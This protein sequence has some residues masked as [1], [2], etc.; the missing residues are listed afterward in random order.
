MRVIELDGDLRRQ[1]IQARIETAMAAQNVLQRAGYEKDLLHET[2]LL[3]ALGAVV[4]V[5]HL[6]DGLARITL[7]HRFDV[8]TAIESPKIEL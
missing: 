4:G 6:R 8:T 1:I 7:A 2:E 5:K 3:T